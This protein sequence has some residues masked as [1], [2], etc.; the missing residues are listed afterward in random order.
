MYNGTPPHKAKGAI[1][2]AWS[3]AAVVYANHLVQNYR[4]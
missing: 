2:Q 4:E 1:S 3:V